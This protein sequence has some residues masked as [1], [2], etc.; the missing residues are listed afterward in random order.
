M[1]SYTPPTCGTLLWLS[2]QNEARSVSIAWCAGF[3][4]IVVVLG[5][6]LL[7]FWGGCLNLTFTLTVLPR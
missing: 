4:V 3:V 7:L 2:Q 1:M 5:G 6:S